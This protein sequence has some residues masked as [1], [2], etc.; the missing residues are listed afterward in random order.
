[1]HSST[2]EVLNMEEMQQRVE[3]F[4]GQV[5]TDLAAAMAG[6]MTNLGHKLGLYRAMAES[7]PMTSEQLSRS[8]VSKVFPTEPQ[9]AKP[10]QIFARAVPVK[11]VKGIRIGITKA[12]EKPWRYGLKDSKFL[13]KP[14]T[15]GVAKNRSRA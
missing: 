7:G 11:I 10:F 8:T 2:T 3:Q 6:V 5:V 13:S 15:A 14:F 12:A 4:A 9:G 1:M